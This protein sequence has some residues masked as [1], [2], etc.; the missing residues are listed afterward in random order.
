MNAAVWSVADHTVFRDR[1]MLVNIGASLVGMA[2]VAEFLGIIGF[3]HMPGQG[4]VRRMAGRT[5]YFSLDNWVVRSF[6]V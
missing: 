6:I 5:A 1:R 3:D 2:G 4:A